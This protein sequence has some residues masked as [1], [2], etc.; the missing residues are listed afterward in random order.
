M[1]KRTITGIL[2][3][4]LLICQN[5]KSELFNRAIHIQAPTIHYD[6]FE[7]ALPWDKALKLK[8]NLIKHLKQKD[9]RIDL[10]IKDFLDE[11]ED[12]IDE[13][14]QKL[15]DEYDYDSMMSMMY[16][17]DLKSLEA[18]RF[19][20]KIQQHGFSVGSAEGEVYIDKNAD[21]IRKDLYQYLDSTSIVFLN[22][23]CA[24]IDKPCCM[25]AGFIVPDKTIFNRALAWGELLKVLDYSEYFTMVDREF[26]TYLYFAF[27]GIDN[28]PYFDW[29]TGLYD[30]KAFGLMQDIIEQ[31]P[32]A[33]AARYF[34]SFVDM[35]KASN[36]KKTEEISMFLEEMYNSI[37]GY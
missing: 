24:E 8:E 19:E 7:S 12:I 26:T 31:Y 11:Y 14:N 15:Y 25:D 34:R 4:L 27:N 22:L 30:R 36:M 20:N 17:P 16:N 3:L 5:A 28:T 13:M 32:E 10:L 35:L 21:F 18:T 29:D 1:L 9:D 6:V 37:P 2:T 33:N 23:Y